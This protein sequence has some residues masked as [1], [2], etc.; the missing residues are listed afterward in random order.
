MYSD[1]Y[2]WFGGSD[3]DTLEED[4]FAAFRVCSQ[5]RAAVLV[6]QEVLGER[7]TENAALA[8][9]HAI[10]T[11]ARRLREPPPSSASVSLH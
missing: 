8:V 1:F 3:A 10:R 7:A 6:A 4:R 11:D 2:A 5:L 9:F